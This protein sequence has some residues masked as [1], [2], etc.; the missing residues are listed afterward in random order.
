MPDDHAGNLC[1]RGN[2]GNTVHQGAQVAV[3]P[4]HDL[5]RAIGPNGAGFDPCQRTGLSDSTAAPI[6]QE[7]TGRIDMSADMRRIA[8]RKSIEFEQREPDPHCDDRNS[9]D[10]PQ[11]RAKS[12]MVCVAGW[13]LDKL[14]A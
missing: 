4:K 2:S 8:G 7:I 6:L 9:G 3:A 13:A 5:R 12:Q 1:F 10:C 11:H 14:P